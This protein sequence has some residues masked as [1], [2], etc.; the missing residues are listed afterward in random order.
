MTLDMAKNDEDSPR[1]A[2]VKKAFDPWYFFKVGIV[3]SS[4]WWR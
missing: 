2:S 3:L 4:P 1:P